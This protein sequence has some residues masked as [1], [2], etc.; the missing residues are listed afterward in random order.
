ML[1]NSHLFI[2]S[3]NRIQ[4]VNGKWRN[5][6]KFVYRFGNYVRNGIYI[7]E[8]SQT[9]SIRD[10]TN[11]QRKTRWSSPEMRIGIWLFSHVGD[12][13]QIESW[14]GESVSKMSSPVYSESQ[15]IANCLPTIISKCSECL[16][17]TSWRRKQQPYANLK[18]KRI[19]NC[20][21]SGAIVSQWFFA[22]MIYSGDFYLLL[23]CQFN[24]KH[25]QIFVSGSR[26]MSNISQS[27]QNDTRKKKG[28]MIYY[29]SL[30][31]LSFIKLVV[32]S[33]I[34]A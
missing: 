31:L 21:D 1:F 10:H 17:K 16:Q 33:F 18:P 27:K 19:L 8:G 6:N 11:N 26:V 15:K 12:D 20:C 14:D 34:A 5:W 7:S 2:L 9:Q 3:F 28:K 24:H 29:P 22:A 13:Q 4:F 30:P 25:V 23:V 32:S